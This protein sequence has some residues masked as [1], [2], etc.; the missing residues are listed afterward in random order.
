MA[1][2]ARCGFVFILIFWVTIVLWVAKVFKVIIVHFKV[3][4]TILIYGNFFNFNKR[5][6]GFIQMCFCVFFFKSLSFLF[7]N[8][9]PL[10]NVLFTALNRTLCLTLPKN[11]L[12]IVL[13]CTFCCCCSCLF[14][15]LFYFVIGC[16]CLLIKMISL[17]ICN[18]S[19]RFVWLFIVFLVLLWRCSKAI[20]IILIINRLDWSIIW[21]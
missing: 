1:F 9:L 12:V 5:G 4:V 8:L 2:S 20:F 7:L 13:A 16:Y 15:D 19:F 21:R 6:L 3:E 11:R 14:H 17:V 18:C 10:A